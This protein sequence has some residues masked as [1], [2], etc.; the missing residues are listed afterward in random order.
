ML[1]EIQVNYNQSLMQQMQGLL[2]SMESSQMSNQLSKPQRLQLLIG[3]LV[4]PQESRAREK[5]KKLRLMPRRLNMM[6][7]NKQLRT[8]E[9]P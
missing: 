1:V 6:L 8:P 7:L 4:K 5:T 3:Q 9:P 2:L